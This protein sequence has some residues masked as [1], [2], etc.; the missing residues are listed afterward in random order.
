MSL[1]F[2]DGTS[3]LFGEIENYVVYEDDDS[4]QVKIT[5]DNGKNG[6]NFSAG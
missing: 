1:T 3:I 5:F 4:I 6:Q 2:Q